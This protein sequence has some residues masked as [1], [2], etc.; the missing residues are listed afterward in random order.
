M[1]S[2]RT[3]IPFA[4][5]NKW[6][7]LFGV[8]ALLTVDA[9][10]LMIPEVLRRVTDR[11]QAGTLDGRGLLHY[12]LFAVFIGVMIM[13]FRYFWR[14]FIINASRRLE[15]ELRNDLF[16]HLL[17][18]ST[19]YY[20]RKKT[21]DLMAHATNDVLAVRMAASAGVITLT[22]AL[23]L[24]IAAVTMMLLTTDVKLTLMALIPMPFLAL[25]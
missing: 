12:T 3:L 13:V 6:V 14:I 25:A 17:S 18:L 22:D 24:N 21:G 9:F 10:Q 20:N 5:R 4:K 23:F 15:Y 1:S 11:L 16:S 2:Y 7:Y 19:S 8:L